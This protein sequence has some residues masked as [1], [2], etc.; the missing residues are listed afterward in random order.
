MPLNEYRKS[1]ALRKTKFLLIV[2][3]TQALIIVLLFGIFAHLNLYIKS[4]KIQERTLRLLHNDFASDYAELLKKSGKATLEVK[5]LRCPALEIFRTV[6]NL[7]P[8]YRKKILS[9]LQI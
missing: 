3:Y 9:N 8:Y 7:N 6:N 2:L 1:W 5:R 4:K